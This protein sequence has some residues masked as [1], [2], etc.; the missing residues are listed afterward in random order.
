[1]GDFNPVTAPSLQY[2]YNSNAGWDG[3]LT[4]ISPFTWAYL[5]VGFGLGLSIV[6]AAWGIFVTGSSLLG[7]AIK[8]PRIRSK[9][10]IRCARGICALGR[11]RAHRPFPFALLG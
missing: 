3:V 7:A 5:G 1:M 9:N 8:A 10:L 6:G 4:G 2:A 11:A